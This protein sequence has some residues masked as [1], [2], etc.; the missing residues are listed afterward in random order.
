MSLFIALFLACPYSVSQGSWEGNLRIWKLDSKLKSFSLIGTIPA[1]G[2]VNSLQVFTPPKDFFSRATWADSIND[3]LTNSAHD[4]NF[5]RQPVI[6]VAGL[7]QEHRFGRWITIKE[8][9]SNG[10]MVF[11]VAPRTS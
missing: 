9:V 11:A 4:P 5:V 6:I 8:G 2:I 7:G 10:A 3:E 1:P